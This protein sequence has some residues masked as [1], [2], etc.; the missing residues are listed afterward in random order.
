MMYFQTRTYKMT[1]IILFIICIVLLTSCDP[2][3]RI[4]KHVPKRDIK[5][6]M[7]YSTWY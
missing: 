5:K 7:K 1:K 3:R 6:A 4:R 2:Y